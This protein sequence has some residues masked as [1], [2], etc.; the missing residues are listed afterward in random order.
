MFDR[1]V[2][3][4]LVSTAYQLQELR[5]QSGLRV[6]GNAKIKLG[7]EPGT[8]EEDLDN[9]AQDILS[10]IRASHDRISDALGGRAIRKGATFPGDGLLTD[11]A[12]Y[13][14]AQTYFM[15]LDR[16]EAT[17]K[18]FDTI[19]ES[20]P[21]G[22]WF[23]SV[24]GV[25]SAIAAI[26]L[27]QIDMDRT[28]NLGNLYAY[29]GL[30]VVV[31]EKKDEET[32]E[33]QLVGEARSRKAHHLVERQYVD[34]K[35]KEST[36]KSITY[37]EF[38]HTKLLGVTADC[39]IKGSGY[40]KSEVYNNYKFRLLNMPEHKRKGEAHIEMMARRYMIKI[41]VMY[42]YEEY[43]CVLGR[44]MPPLY[45]EKK[46]RL[47][48]SGPLFKGDVKRSADDIV[49]DREAADKLK[50]VSL[51]RKAER[52]AEEKLVIAGRKVTKESPRSNV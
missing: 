33:V 25:G 2:M 27:S 39:L 19:V 36:R 42:F 34:K 47:Y 31:A 22:P 30:D 44:E 41:F 1:R 28:P 24:R 26:M 50:E 3:K 45:H 35:G 12:E 6:V 16:E 40:F 43:M 29:C 18:L 15:L 46:L 8:K 11:K 9:T 37:N 51:Q 5:I 17:F 20:H 21:M 38:L 32:G 10:Q 7:Q 14:L 48:H 52:A 13:T 4:S 49:R 23:E